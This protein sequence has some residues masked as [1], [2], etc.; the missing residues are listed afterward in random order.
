MKYPVSR[1]LFELGIKNYWGKYEK[2]LD[3][4]SE[5]CLPPITF[6]EY[7]DGLLYMSISNSEKFKTWTACFWCKRGITSLWYDFVKKHP[8]QKEN[9]Q[10]FDGWLV[11][12]FKIKE[13]QYGSS[14]HG[15][16]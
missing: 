8:D 5:W 2:H 14:S 12:K 1:K 13:A 9:L 16:G 6:M 10:A 11:N 3:Q 4:L 15:T 7:I